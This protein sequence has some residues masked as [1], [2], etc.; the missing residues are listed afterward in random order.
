M[1]EIQKGY[2]RVTEVISS[3]DPD[4]KLQKAKAERMDLVEGAARRGK[5]LHILA[6][7]IFSGK[8]LT[9]GDMV[10]L[11]T[12]GAKRVDAITW[13]SDLQAFHKL[14]GKKLIKKSKRFHDKKTKIT[15]EL[16]FVFS[17]PE[18]SDLKTGA[19]PTTIKAQLGAYAWLGKIKGKRHSCI[20]APLGKKPR[21]HYFSAEEC[22]AAWQKILSAFLKKKV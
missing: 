7:R 9:P 12:F 4:K 5:I 15:G 20:H 22:R 1:S 21:V 13:V 19:M 2:S 14:Q 11:N 10:L 3:I 16:D 18:L 17:G 6:E 8:A